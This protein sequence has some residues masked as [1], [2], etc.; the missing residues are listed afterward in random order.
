MKR[1]LPN[2]WQPSAPLVRFL[3]AKS[4]AHRHRSGERIA[5]EVFSCQI[6]GECGVGL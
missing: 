5:G 6:V 1:P 2:I 4:R 3:A